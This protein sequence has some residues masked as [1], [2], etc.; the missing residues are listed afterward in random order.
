MHQIAQDELM[1][2]NKHPTA[3][4]LYELFVERLLEMFP[5]TSIRVHKSQIT[6]SNRHIYACASFLYVKKNYAVMYKQTILGPLWLILNPLITVLLY[7]FVFGNHDAVYFA[8]EH[9]KFLG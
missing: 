9:Q 2:F 6:F 7:T 5:S 4:S 1:F 8:Y 3:Y